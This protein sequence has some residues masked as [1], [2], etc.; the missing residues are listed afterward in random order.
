LEPKEAK[1][2]IVHLQV[3]GEGCD[4][5]GFHH[6][7]VRHVP[8]R[9]GKPVTY[10]ARWPTNK[11]MQHARDRIRE[12]TGRSRLWLHVGE[13]VGDL[14]R[15]LHGWAAYFKYGNSTRH[16]DK[17]RHYARMRLA[18]FIGKRHRRNRAFGWW[19]V[20]VASPNQLGLVSLIGIVVAPRPFRDWR[21]KPNAGGE[22]RR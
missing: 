20:G 11:A 7:L 4:F 15:F 1:T 17:V 19:V 6:R 2:R 9:G 21:K 5:L 13:I 10:L 12:L 14:N 3:G 22:R 8:R 18:L 16:F